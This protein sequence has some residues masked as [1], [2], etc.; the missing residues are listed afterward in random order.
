MKLKQ[1]KRICLT[2]YTEDNQPIQFLTSGFPNRNNTGLEFS[3]VDGLFAPNLLPDLE[4]EECDYQDQNNQGI[5]CIV[6]VRNTPCKGY[7]PM[8]VFSADNSPHKPELLTP[9][10]PQKIRKIKDGIRA[11]V[12]GGALRLDSWNDHTYYPN[13]PMTFYQKVYIKVKRKHPKNV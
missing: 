5:E 7:R 12:K 8:W 4:Y 11:N 9:Y 3:S 10:E 2:K 6:Y 13:K 1:T